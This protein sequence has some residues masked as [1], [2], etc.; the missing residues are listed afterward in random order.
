MN[1]MLYFLPFLA[2][3]FIS[4]ILTVATRRIGLLYGIVSKPRERDVHK[5]PVPRIGGVAVFL[6]FVLVSVFLSIFFRDDLQFGKPFLFGIDRRIFS[7]FAGGLLITSA[8]LYDDIKGLK[9]WHKLIFQVLVSLIVIAGGIGIDWLANPFGD[10]LN[11]NSIYVPILTI[12]GVV[13]HFSLISDLLTLIWLVGMMNVINFVDGVDG[14]AG[15]LSGIAAITL[16]LLSLSVGQSATAMVSVVLAGAI[17]GFLVLNFPPAK[18]FMGDSGSM[19][20][21]FMLGVLPLIS[22]GK[23]A[24]AFLVLGFPIVDGVF[25]AA[26]RLLRRQNPLTTPD[27]THLHH[28]FLLAGF[29]QRQAIL[30]MY[31]ISIAFGWVALRASTMEKLIASVILVLLLFTIIA[32]L[33]SRAKKTGSQQA[34]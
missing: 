23:L 14:L 5:K 8:M 15:G 26:S 6:S 27:K 16:F 32:L 30:S 22:G 28:R 25:V 13:Y 12:N 19:F 18:I 10:Q 4:L 11:L 31:L 29:S 1:F 21:G 20:I 33:W 9:A 24:T 17:M 2:A 3:F 34:N 7:I